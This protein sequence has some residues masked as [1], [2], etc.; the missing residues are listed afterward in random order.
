MSR[1]YKGR[2]GALHV[3]ILLTLFQCGVHSNYQS[4]FARIKDHS[5][6]FKDPGRLSK[7]YLRVQNKCKDTQHAQKGGRYTVATF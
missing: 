2:V 6:D 3:Y 5:K 1:Q 4:V 7:N